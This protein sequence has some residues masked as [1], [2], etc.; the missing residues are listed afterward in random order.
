M[1]TPATA[2][3]SPS[4]DDSTLR[5][6]F[7]EIC[8]P[9]CADRGARLQVFCE[10][11]WDRLDTNPPPADILLNNL[12]TI[13]EN[14]N[15]LLLA[16][17]V[18]PDLRSAADLPDAPWK[19]SIIQGLRLRQPSLNSVQQKLQMPDM[20]GSR[21]FKEEK[22]VLQDA[23]VYRASILLAGDGHT[24]DEQRQKI[25]QWLSEFPKDDT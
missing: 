18:I 15:D 6:L 2:A 25:Q 10:C 7:Q 8:K 24:S 22:Q 21:H 20:E 16:Q 14:K 1:A 12:A 13:L 11:L 3:V 9:D 17:L 4:N 19:K 5:D 23:E